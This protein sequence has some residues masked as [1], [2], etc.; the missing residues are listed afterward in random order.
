M[1]CDECARVLSDEE[2]AICPGLHC[3]QCGFDLCNACA[4]TA[5]GASFIRLLQPESFL[6]ESRQTQRESTSP[7][8]GASRLGVQYDVQAATSSSSKSVRR[9]Q[10]TCTAP[11]SELGTPISLTSPPVEWRQQLRSNGIHSTERRPLRRS[12]TQNLKALRDFERQASSAFFDDLLSADE[13]TAVDDHAQ[14]VQ[15][16]RSATPCATDRALPL[17][18]QTP[19]AT[20]PIHLAQPLEEQGRA[21]ASSSRRPP[22]RTMAACIKGH[23]TD[24]LGTITPRAPPPRSRTPCSSGQARDESRTAPGTPTPRLSTPSMRTP[25]LAAHVAADNGTTSTPAS[26][27]STPRARTPLCP[28]HALED[29]GATGTSTPRRPRPPRTR[30]PCPAGLVASPRPGTPGRKLSTPTSPACLELSARLG[31]PRVIATPPSSRNAARSTLPRSN[32]IATT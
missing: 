13:D 28:G 19:R 21:V 7:S 25:D 9:D 1:R 15:S 14:G 22:P 31:T 23:A 30:T 2:L 20:T 29:R 17:R 5:T 6:H 12:R 27:A 10:R 24:D 4:G 3:R 16:L 32:M 11:S 8:T 18:A 26:H